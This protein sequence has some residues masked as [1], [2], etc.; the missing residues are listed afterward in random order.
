MLSNVRVISYIQVVATRESV[1][2]R[3]LAKISRQHV[4][5]HALFFSEHILS[6]KKQLL[7]IEHELCAHV[8]SL[9][10]SNATTRSFSSM[11]SDDHDASMIRYTCDEFESILH[12][13]N[14]YFAK[15]LIDHDLLRESLS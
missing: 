13:M 12:Q 4:L 10:I 8:A 7:A 3:S 2:S 14:V 9:N 1:V 15:A 11:T 5:F 6:L